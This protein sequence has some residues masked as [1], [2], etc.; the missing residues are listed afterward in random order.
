VA[1]HWSRAA[2]FADTQDK[3]EN[4]GMGFD[5]LRSE[6]QSWLDNMP[7]NLQESPKAERL[8]EAVDELDGVID[9]VEEITSTEIEFPG[10]C[11]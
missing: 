10:M 9:L 7:E 2:R 3:I 8:Q 6:L 4:A 5:D 1:K 11:D